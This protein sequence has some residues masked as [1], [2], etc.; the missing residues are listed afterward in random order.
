ME[1]L[2]EL[3]W[4]VPSE[5]IVFA[6]TVG[7]TLLRALILGL[8]TWYMARAARRSF[9]HATDRTGA[10]ASVRLL[11]GRLVYLAILTLGVVTVMDTF[12]VPLS[13]LVTVIGVVGLGISLALQDILKNFFAG[14]YLLFER[15]FRLGDEISVKDH[16]GIVETIGVRTTTLRTPENVHIMIPNA[17]VFSEAVA[18]R[19]YERSAGAARAKTET[20]A[21]VAGGA[22]DRAPVG[23]PPAERPRELIPAPMPLWASL[24][25]FARCQ[26]R[27]FW[28]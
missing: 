13:T 19:T 28:V 5:W 16:R 18:N 9:E 8:F 24:T 15:P 27:R 17:I 23:R 7:P 25:E 11:L 20:P 3:R 10:D 14:T 22:T 6:Q 21:L 26:I 2:F 4:W 12:G 1:Q